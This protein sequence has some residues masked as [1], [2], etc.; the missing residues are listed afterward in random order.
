MWSFWGSEFLP[1]EGI[2]LF[3]HVWYKLRALPEDSNF[4]GK[5]NTL[6][7]SKALP[8][9]LISF[10]C[11]N[12][13]NTFKGT[14]KKIHLILNQR[15]VIL[16]QVTFGLNSGR[17]GV[18]VSWLTADPGRILA[19]TCGPPSCLIMHYSLWGPELIAPC[20]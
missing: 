6:K 14:F 9:L 11:K 12:K 13:K 5:L 20:N 8:S 17:T 7:I 3:M 16:S 1:R 19:S 10:L 2:I 18:A 4:R 15:T